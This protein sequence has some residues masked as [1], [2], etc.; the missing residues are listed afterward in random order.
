MAK[1]QTTKRPKISDDEKLQV[2]ARKL[3]GHDFALRLDEYG[4]QRVV[5]GTVEGA[6]KYDIAS[7]GLAVRVRNVDPLAGISSL[8][9]NQRTAGE[10]YR[11]DFEYCNREG[12]PAGA[13]QDFVDGGSKGGGVPDRILEAHQRIKGARA[14]IAHQEMVNIM[15]D[16]CGRFMS[17]KAIADRDRN[18]RDVVKKLLCMALDK[19]AVY[20]RI[21]P[22]PK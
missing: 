16:V 11:E 9:K 15:D 18:V 12:F 7:S 1:R 21:V 6:R 4:R 8:T 2:R 20:Y 3:I 13:L 5:S 19:L 10:K 22:A 14:A 17:I